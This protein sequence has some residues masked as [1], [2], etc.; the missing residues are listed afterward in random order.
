MRILIAFF[1]L[2]IY[3]QSCDFFS[4][5]PNDQIACTEEFRTITVTITGGTLDDFYT[6]RKS[7]EETIRY[8]K[9]DGLTE[10][11]Y[12]ILDDSY[13]SKFVN[14]RETFTFIGVINE[15][16]VVEENYV[17]AADFCHIN[18]VSGKTEID[19]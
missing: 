9:E 6:I 8:S 19:L 10:N 18:L 15:V 4:D 5:D 2:S 17:I 14:S 7:T 16:V 1:I 11:Y 12:P 13:Q 3:C